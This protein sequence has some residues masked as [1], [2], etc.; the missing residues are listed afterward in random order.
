MNTTQPINLK[1][2][3]LLRKKK[4]LNLALNVLISVL[5]ISSLFIKLVLLDGLIA[6]RFFTVDGNLFTTLVSVA[7]VWVNIRELKAGRENESRRMFFLQL[8]SA[9]TEAVIFI[10][11]MLGYLPIFPDEPVITPYNMFCLHV[12]IPV[13]A[14]LRFVFFEKPC[15]ILPPSRLLIGAIPIGVYGFGVVN[16]I[17]LD[18][19]PVSMAPYSFL[20]FENN[21]LWY[22]VFALVVIPVIGF[23]W[24]WLFYR[25]NLRASLLWYRAEDVERL[26]TA[27]VKA[28]SH[29]DVVNSAILIIY[30]ALA[31]VVLMFSLRSTSLTSTKVQN[32]LMAY[33]SFYMTD[34]FSNMIDNGAWEM[35]DGVLYKGSLRVG[36]GTEQN[37]ALNI[38]PEKGVSY[39]YTVY[40]QAAYLSPAVA[41]KYDGLDYVA[42]SH[43]AGEFAPVRQCGETLKD[44]VVARVIASSKYDK[45]LI[46]EEAEQDGNNFYHCCIAFGDDLWNSGTGIIELYFPASQ[47]VTQAK[48]A[49]YNADLEM[50]VVIFAAFAL[51][52]ILTNK[53][54]HVLEKSV[55][56][57]RA[58][59]SGRT[60]EESITLGK[61]IVFSGLERQLNVIREINES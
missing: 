57:L 45:H 43:S 46:Y 50:V 22:F 30:C 38:F 36:D 32:E 6:L 33:I 40:V 23:L 25:L 9:V 14:V 44:E 4:Q 41:A 53:W 28:L 60:P 61:T 29:F 48:N 1:D 42:V 55:D 31:I 8:S 21:F 58:I 16:A 19:L 5:G 13:L 10:V 7:A 18:I 2:D 52:Y 54:I 37:A 51:L 59:A 15:G 24:S 11:V 47:L 35:K 3:S 39:D 12:A 26:Q 20:D 27:R 34:D 56:F 17:K 49:E